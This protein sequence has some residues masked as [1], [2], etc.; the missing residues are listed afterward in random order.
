LI[1]LSFDLANSLPICL[2]TVTRTD[3]A[4]KRIT[5]YNL[6][7]TIGDDTWYPQPGLVM[8]VL[9]ERSDGTLPSLGFTMQL[10]EEDDINLMT[11]ADVHAKKYKGAAVR[12]D[13]TNAANPTIADFIALGELRGTTTYSVTGAASFEIIS[14]F[15]IP[16]DIFIRTYQLLCDADFGDPVRCKVPTFPYIYGRSLGDL[17]TNETVALGEFRRF[18]FGSSNDPTDYANR[19]LEATVGGVTGGSLPAPSQTVGSTVTDGGVTWTTRN[20]WVRAA[21]V[22]SVTDNRTIVL[23]GLPDPRASV[24]SWYAPGSIFFATGDHQGR[25]FRI[26]AW[27]AGTLTLQTYLPCGLVQAGDWCEIAPD[28]DH[29]IAMCADKYNN[30][31]NY[32]GFPYQQGAKA[33]AQQLGYPA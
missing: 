4:V 22:A 9:A 6:P 13:L 18:R 14:K 32:R 28:C 26:G 30:A 20:A 5:P 2:L 23:T 21:M 1:N 15:A 17:Q 8:G 29:T 3:A 12:V 7:I 10:S 16:R 27:S 24:D 33:Q 25:R 31:L 11:L 19:Y